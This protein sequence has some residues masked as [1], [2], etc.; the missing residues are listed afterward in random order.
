MFHD[1]NIEVD[2]DGDAVG[3]IAD[4][5]ALVVLESVTMR[6]ERQRDASL[7][8]TEGRRD[9]GLRRL[10][11]RRLSRRAAQVRRHRAIDIGVAGR[12]GGS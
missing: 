6:T 1:G 10:R 3:L 11:A 2:S 12:T 7:R 8:G 5:G 4:E 9:G